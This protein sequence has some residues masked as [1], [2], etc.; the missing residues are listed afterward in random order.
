MAFD[1]KGITLDAFAHLITLGLDRP[2]VDK[3]GIPGLF[4]IHLEFAIDDQTPGFDRDHFPPE[5]PTAAAPNGPSIFVA[6][7][8]QTGLKLEAAKGPRDILVI[9]H[10]ERPSEN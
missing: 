9:D 10:V 7:Q 2:V 4:D 1:A 3:T 8:Q 6:I 5:I